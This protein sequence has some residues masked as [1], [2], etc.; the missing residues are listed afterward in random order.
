MTETMAAKLL[1]YPRNA[2]YVAAWDPEVGRKRILARTIA[3]RPLA[4][5]RTEELRG[6][7]KRA[8]DNG[9]TQ[10]EIRGL[11]VHLAFYAGWPTAGNAGGPSNDQMFGLLQELLV[12]MRGMQGGPGGGASGGAQLLDGL[13][14]AGQRAKVFAAAQGNR[15]QAV[16]AA[17]AQQVAQGHVAQRLAQ[18][19]QRNHHR[20]VDEEVGGLFYLLGQLPG[21][22]LRCQADELDQGHR[23]HAA[24][25]VEYRI[26]VEQVEG[27]VSSHGPSSS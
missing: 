26:V 25:E 6:H 3:G 23:Q 13:G 8:L 2:W 27:S 22:L 5:Y 16:I 19:V 17:D 20:G 7:M 4:L 21:E 24:L 10:D 9:V 12:T 14:I 18:L 15:L 1:D 11:I